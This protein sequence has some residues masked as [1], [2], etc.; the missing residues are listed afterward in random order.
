MKKLPATIDRKNLG[1]LAPTARIRD[2]A[3]LEH[4][5]VL[6]AGSGSSHA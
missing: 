1:A 5:I 4:P 6:E 3:G 2:L